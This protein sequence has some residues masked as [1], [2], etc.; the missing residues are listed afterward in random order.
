MDQK[1]KKA[2]SAAFNDIGEKL[3]IIIDD[4]RHLPD[5]SRDFFDNS[6]EFLKEGGLFIVE[7][8]FLAPHNSNL[9]E[10]YFS[11]LEYIKTKVRFADILSLKCD[12][13]YR[14][15]NLMVILK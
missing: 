3:D 2:V 10:R 5:Y 12:I 6:I 14:D 8:L 1:D 7:D 11:N 4:G 15:N 9:K 13:N